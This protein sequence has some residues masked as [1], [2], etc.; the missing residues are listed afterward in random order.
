MHMLVLSMVISQQLRHQAK[1]VLFQ[2]ASAKSK[3]DVTLYNSNSSSSSII[4]VIVI[5]VV[6]VVVV[7]VIIKLAL[8]DHGLSVITS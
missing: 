8:R 4:I 6:I 2:F 3:C 7:V 1:Q 5:V